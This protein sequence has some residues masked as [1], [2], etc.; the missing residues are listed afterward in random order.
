MMVIPPAHHDSRT[1]LQGPLLQNP[2]KKIRCFGLGAEGL[3]ETL[4]QKR[5]VLEAPF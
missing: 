3:G 2:L 4:S 5:K 1:L